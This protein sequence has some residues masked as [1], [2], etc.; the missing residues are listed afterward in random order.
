MFDVIAVGNPVY[1]VVKTP[2]V[3]SL[4]RVLSGCSVNAALTAKKL[5]MKKVAVVGCI[6]GD[7]KKHFINELK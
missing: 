4:G 1:D 3:E 7:Y 5:G 6:G 2:F